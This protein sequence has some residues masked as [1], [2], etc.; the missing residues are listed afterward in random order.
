MEK[1][2]LMEVKTL[3]VVEAENEIGAYELTKT[4]RW[5]AKGES[6]DV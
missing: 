1:N 4:R 3:V 5:T 2:Y 6:V